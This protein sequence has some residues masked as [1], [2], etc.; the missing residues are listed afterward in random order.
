M[1]TQ[2]RMRST[3]VRIG[4]VSLLSVAVAG[5]GSGGD[6]YS[7]SGEDVTAYCVDPD[8][9]DAEGNYEVVDED[10]CDDD[11]YRSSHG[12]YF[13]YYGGVRSGSKVKGGTTVRPQNANITTEKGK[14]IQRSGFGNRSTSGG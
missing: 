7:D 11:G 13:F 8:S 14:T 4:M 12:G 3:A 2:R 6:E 1:R 9:L 5:C 10:L